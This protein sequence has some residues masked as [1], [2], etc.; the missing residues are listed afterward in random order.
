M[1][2]RKKRSLDHD[3]MTLVEVMAAFF[4]LMLASKA[5]FSCVSGY[6]RVIQRSRELSA[7]AVSLERAAGDAEYGTAAEI[8]L[9]IGGEEFVEPGYYM[10]ATASNSGR[11]VSGFW[12]DEAAMEE[13]FADEE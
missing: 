1:R 11:S 4:I 3:G 2:K 10:K 7:A 9:E 12:I 6:S 13:I 8:H 5:V